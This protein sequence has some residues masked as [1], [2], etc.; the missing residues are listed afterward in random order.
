MATTGLPDG[1]LNQA[2]TAPALTAGGG[3]LELVG[4][5]RRSASCRTDARVQRRHLGHP[6]P[7]RNVHVHGS[8]ERLAEQRHEELSLFVLAPLELQTLSGPSRRRAG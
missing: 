7:E 2:Y 5:R 1:N 3:T 6:D 8:G 4:G